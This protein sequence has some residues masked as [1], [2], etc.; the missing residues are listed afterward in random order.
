M[1]LQA[2]GRRI[3]PRTSVRLMFR[4]VANPDRDLLADPGFEDVVRRGMRR[5]LFEERSE[6]VALLQRYV[7]A[8]SDVLDDVR[9]PVSIVHGAADAWTPPAMAAALERRLG[10][11][12]D[13]TCLPGLGHYGALVRT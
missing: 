7:R 4:D 11:R 13:R 1:R 9:C 12:C 5:A 10:D 8:W 2:V 6:Y 3:A